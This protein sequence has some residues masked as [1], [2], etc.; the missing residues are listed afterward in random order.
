M[1]SMDFNCQDMKHAYVLYSL[2]FSTGL[3]SC[4]Y[5]QRLLKGIQETRYKMKNQNIKD[6]TGQSLQ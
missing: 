5:R 4:S 2:G 6:F 3:Y 1:A